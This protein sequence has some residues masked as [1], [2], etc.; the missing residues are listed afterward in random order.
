MLSTNL[1]TYTS[2]PFF[3]S[4]RA[5]NKIQKLDENQYATQE[6]IEKLP[7]HLNTVN[8]SVINLDFIRN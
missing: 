1:K 7:L 8:K 4:F 3:S 5:I 6:R 2:R